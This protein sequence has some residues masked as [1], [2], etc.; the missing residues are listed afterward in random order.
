MAI[1][2]FKLW[3]L[4]DRPHEPEAWEGRITIVGITY[5]LV[6]HSGYDDRGPYV[7]GRI[8]L[9]GKPNEALA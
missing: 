9:R 1:G 5:L 8:E 4:P 7:E 2:S 6:A 3:R